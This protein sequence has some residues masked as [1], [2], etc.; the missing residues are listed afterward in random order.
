MD[1]MGQNAMDKAN[2]EAVKLRNQKA[3]AH[4]Q[5]KSQDNANKSK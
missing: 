1:F 5:S 4:L 2:D 3:K